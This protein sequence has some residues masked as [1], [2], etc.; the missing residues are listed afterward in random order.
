MSRLRTIDPATTPEST[1][2]LFDGVLAKLGAGPNMMGMTANSPAV[3]RRYRRLNGALA[4]GSLGAPLREQI[5]PA[6]AEANGC[7]YCLAAHTALGR[8]LRR[9]SS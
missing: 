6:V 8:D 9:P 1:K 5:A 3:P 4:A 2:Q 7:T